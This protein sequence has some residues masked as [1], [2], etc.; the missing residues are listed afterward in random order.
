[1]NT[2]TSWLTNSG[3]DAQALSSLAHSSTVRQTIMSAM[4]Q[5]LLSDLGVAGT[6]DPVQHHP[7]LPKLDIPAVDADE[8][9]PEEWEAGDDVKG[10]PLDRREAK[11]ACE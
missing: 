3:C 1:M 8:E 2:L 9:P 10:N 11:L 4:S 7:P 5:Q 6:S